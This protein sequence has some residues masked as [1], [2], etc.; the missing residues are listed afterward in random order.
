MKKH[1]NRIAIALDV[2]W[3]PLA[4]IGALILVTLGSLLLTLGWFYE[5]RGFAET[6]HGFL[7]AVMVSS[8]LC[9]GMVYGARM[10]VTS[11]TARL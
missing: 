3:H 11:R 9:T 2:T 1:I 10:L 8:L 4:H 7:I 5:S 6:E